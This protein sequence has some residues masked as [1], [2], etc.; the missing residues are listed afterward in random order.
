MYDDTYIKDFCFAQG[1]DGPPFSLAARV[2]VNQIRENCGA[3]WFAAIVRKI[4]SSNTF[5]VEYEN[6]Q[7][8][9]DSDLLTEY[10]DAQFIRPYLPNSVKKK[11]FD[12]YDEVEVLYCGG[13]ARGKISKIDGLQFVVKVLHLGKEIQF[14]V[15]QMRPAR[16][17]NEKEWVFNFQV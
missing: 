2:E 1:A 5:L 3:S 14:G 11:D 15:D 8:E 13:W 10:V 12:I 4:L 6:F 17:W 9:I 16:F 7:A